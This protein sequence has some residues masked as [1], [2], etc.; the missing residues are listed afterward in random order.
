MFLKDI[1]PYDQNKFKS[2]FK[3]NPI[4]Q[5]LY[6][7]HEILIFSDLTNTLF[8]LY[9]QIKSGENPIQL[10]P[11]KYLSF[12]VVSVVPFYYLQYLIKLNSGKIYDIG[13]G[14][15]DFK[16]YVPN[17][18]GIECNESKNK[19]NS[20][21]NTIDLYDNLDDC[22]YEKNFEKFESAFAICSIHFH[23]FSDIRNRV[24]QFS[25]LISKG[26]MGFIA[27]NVARMLEH[28]E[29]KYSN[30]N[31]KFLLDHEYQ[32]SPINLEIIELFVRKELYDLPLNIEVFECSIS[33]CFDSFLNGNVRLVFS[34]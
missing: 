31:F 19:F 1:N 21:K 27:L 33:K 15:N 17:I 9:D 6:N 16:K 10:T 25:S 11:R 14:W 4:Y 5:K 32:K 26:G 18:I 2:S 30:S 12:S 22:F 8:T 13:C 28:E 29:K 20:I 3:N 24:L 7:D 34:K 23:P